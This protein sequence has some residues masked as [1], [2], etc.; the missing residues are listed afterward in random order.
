MR[1]K[2]GWFNKDKPRSIAEL[3]DVMGFNLWSIAVNRV[4]HMEGQGFKVNLPAQTLAVIGEYLFFLMQKIDRYVYSRL[5]QE[6][7]NAFIQ[8]LAKKLINTMVENQFDAHGAGDY[9]TPFIVR[10][11]EALGAY[12]RFDDA[13]DESEASYPS[14]VYLGDSIENLVKDL[15]QGWVK[16]QVIEIEGLGAVESL[17]RVLP[18]IVESAE[19]VDN[20]QDSVE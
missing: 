1:L 18:R 9:A 3:G 14:L 12:A 11:N 4:K 7:R 15:N 5:P 6:Q 16:E 8:S 13:R 20:N 2:S 10:M 19:N 17:M